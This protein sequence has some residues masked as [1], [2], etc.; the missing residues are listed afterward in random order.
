MKL[1]FI[2]GKHLAV[3][4]IKLMSASKTL[5]KYLFSYCVVFITPLIFVFIFLNNYFFEIYKDE[6]YINN[7]AE[8]KRFRDIIDS[9]VEQIYNNVFRMTFEDN[10]NESYNNDAYNRSK[11]FRKLY[12]YSLANDLIS[13]IVYFQSNLDFVISADGACQNENIGDYLFTY[14]HW[15]ASQMLEEI[16]KYKYPYWRPLEEIKLND[17]TTNRYLSF[18]YPLTKTSSRIKK[19]FLF[20][21]KEDDFLKVLDIDKELNEKIYLIINRQG[22]IVFSSVTEKEYF[23]D[24][25]KCAINNSGDETEQIEGDDYVASYKLSGVN[26]WIFINVLPMDVA[27]RKANHLQNIAIVFIILIVAIGALIIYFLTYINYNPLKSLAMLIKNSTEISPDSKN[28]IEAAKQAI[29]YFVQSEHTM[30]EKVN[31]SAESTRMTMIY[32][33]LRG[34]IKNIKEFNSEA[35]DYGIEI[36]GT[37]FYV[38][39]FLLKDVSKLAVS[40]PAIIQKIEKT[41]SHNIDSYGVENID[42]NSFVFILSTNLLP[43]EQLKNILINVRRTIIAE[44]STDMMI[45]VSKELGAEDNIYHS[46]LEAIT[47]IKYK[48][49]VESDD[50]VI[51]YDNSNFI[52]FNQYPSA[53]IEKLKSAL[54]D[55][56]INSFK[57]VSKYLIN[58]VKNGNSSIFIAQ[59]ICYDMMITIFKIFLQDKDN[60][61]QFQ[62]YKL[63]DMNHNDINKLIGIVSVVCDEVEEY[64]N[65]KGITL[66]SN[67]LQEIKKYMNDNLA[68][69]GFS[70]YNLADKFGMSLSNISHYFKKSSGETLSQYLSQLRMEKAKELLRDTNLSVNEIAERTGYVNPSSFIRKFKQMMRV[71]PGEYREMHNL[72]QVN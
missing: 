59:C 65:N 9:R 67:Q 16:Y 37:I 61:Y 20:Q 10:F 71:T 51:M 29:H 28:E 36:K 1:G 44:H 17:D 31:M 72:K 56:D 24:I 32:D 34:Y 46:Y 38:A 6:L 12:E 43:K 13:N 30:R 23:K 62:K 60:G 18:I 11:T 15:P 49:S 63:A 7:R 2:Y 54:M 41:I 52:L 14:K 40:G 69:S 5:Y 4:I 66:N 35:R 27:M 53:E 25:F 3:I 42:N 64:I 19:A 57:A 58:Y 22:E 47:A 45:G 26:D 39:V 50:N 8:T 70:L 21:I 48:A 33:M 55:N 68:N